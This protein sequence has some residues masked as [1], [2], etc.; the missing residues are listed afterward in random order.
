VRAALAADLRRRWRFSPANLPTPTCTRAFETACG[1]LGP[2]GR[3]LMESTS[4]GGFSAGLRRSNHLAA[5]VEFWFSADW[6]PYSPNL[7][8]L[9]L[10]FARVLQPKGQATPHANLVAPRPFAAAE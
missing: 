5:V 3:S 8:L 7:N 2:E 4:F 1:P 6:P 9:E 10:S